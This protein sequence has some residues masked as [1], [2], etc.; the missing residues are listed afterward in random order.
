V[1]RIL[2]VC[3]G[4]I[5]RSPMAA[6]IMRREFER[7]SALEYH[8]TS[9]GTGAWD[10][11]SASEGA[12]LVGLENELDLSQH[13][14]ALVTR[15][16]IEKMDLIL[17]M[18]R[19]H[20]TRVDDLGGEGKTFLLGEFAGRDGEDAEVAD[21]FGSSLEVYRKTYKTLDDLGREAV[22]RILRED[23]EPDQ[24]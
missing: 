24:R 15:E 17:T 22:D 13:R 8:V 5:C 16:L 12:Y 4:N 21:P 7:R 3:T 14:A 20:R 18:A 6:A 23:G 1:R 9:A 11:A 2:L 19:H 10:G